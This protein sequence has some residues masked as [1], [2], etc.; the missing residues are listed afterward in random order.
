MTR[1]VL[2]PMLVSATSL[3][4]GAGLATAAGPAQAATD[5]FVHL[6]VQNS[7][8]SS[9]GQIKEVWGSVSTTYRSTQIWSGGDA[10]DNVIYP[11][12][13]LDESNTFNGRALCVDGTRTV[14]INLNRQFTPH[15]GQAVWI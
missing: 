7:H 14:W 11:K 2:Y 8:C 6:V 15:E 3:L 1:R 10:G 13:R 12:V 5:G 4:M 9:N